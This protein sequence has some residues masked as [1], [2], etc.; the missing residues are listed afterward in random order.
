MIKCTCIYKY[1]DEKGNIKGYKLKDKH[2]AIQDISSTDLKNAIRAAQIEVDNLTLTS[3][4]RLMSKSSL[5]VDEDKISNNRNK[6]KI[7]RR[8]QNVFKH[9]GIEVV[10]AKYLAYP[11]D[12]DD[13]NSLFKR[14]FDLSRDS[15]ADI[16]QLV[17][18]PTPII[19]HF[20]DESFKRNNDESEYGGY[21]KN[22]HNELNEN[23][24]MGGDIE[25]KVILLVLRK[26]GGYRTV[27]LSEVESIT[28]LGNIAQGIGNMIV[29]RDTDD[30][31]YNLSVITL[32]ANK[33][34]VVTSLG[35]NINNMEKAKL[36]ERILVS[37]IDLWLGRDATKNIL[38]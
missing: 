13:I 9:L 24:L 15:I 28:S 37:T 38:D 1:R 3:D 14:T 32:D 30:I 16:R 36:A 12:G 5:S 35:K 33:N 27:L 18:D 22:V 23:I 4:N 34:P 8:Y 11:K 20:S 19:G 26:D 25:S 29:K 7:G 10:T 21:Y 31:K 6:S 17:V 2:G